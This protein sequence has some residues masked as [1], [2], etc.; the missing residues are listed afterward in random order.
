MPEDQLSDPVRDGIPQKVQ[1]LGIFTAS[2][3]WHQKISEQPGGGER[4]RFIDYLGRLFYTSLM[5]DRAMSYPGHN[6]FSL[7]NDSQEKD[8]Q[9]WRFLGDAVDYGDLHDAAHTTKH[10]DARQRTKWYLNP[11]LSPFFR[12]PESHVKEPMYVDVATVRSWLAELKIVPPIVEVPQIRKKTTEESK[13][14]SFLPF[15]DDLKK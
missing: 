7:P 9:V 15:W 6:G 3:Y 11:I 10:K 4:Q 13:Q 14:P 1:A 12:L 5:E 8:E 2:A